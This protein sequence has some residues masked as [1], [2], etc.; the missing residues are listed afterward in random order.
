MVYLRSN[1]Q[2]I[3]KLVNEIGRR[4]IYSYI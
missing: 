2:Y 4:V 3:Y 1:D